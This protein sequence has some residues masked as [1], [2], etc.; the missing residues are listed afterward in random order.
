MQPELHLEVAQP[1]AE[2]EAFFASSYEKIQAYAHMLAEQGELRGLIGPR[3][4]PRI[5]PRQKGSYH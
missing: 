1:G 5:W 3:E 4:L 2:V